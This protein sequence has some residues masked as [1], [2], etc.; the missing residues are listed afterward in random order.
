M[1]TKQAE[2]RKKRSLWLDADMDRWVQ[3]RA[4][5][6]SASDSVIVRQILRAAMDAEAPARQDAGRVA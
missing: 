2:P 6:A 1:A 4:D 3:A 5:G